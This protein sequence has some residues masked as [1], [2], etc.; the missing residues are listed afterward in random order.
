VRWTSLHKKSFVKKIPIEFA[1][2]F[3]GGG[4]AIQIEVADPRVIKP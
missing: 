3:D 2:I 4:G 1:K